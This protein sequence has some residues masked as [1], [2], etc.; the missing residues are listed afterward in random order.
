MSESSIDTPTYRAWEQALKDYNA[1]LASGEGV[2]EA[3]QAARKAQVA[4]LTW[5]VWQGLSTPRELMELEQAIQRE[6]TR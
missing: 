1:T 5:R 6:Q 2:E 4:H 3:Y